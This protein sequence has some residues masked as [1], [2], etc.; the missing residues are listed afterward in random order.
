MDNT[1]IAQLFIGPLFLVLA[2][3]FRAFPP[4]SI[5]SFYGYR[6]AYSMTSQE[7]WDEANRYS[8]NLML[9]I[10]IIVT[11]TQVVLQFTVEGDLKMLIPTIMLVTLLIAM[12]PATEVHLRKHFDKEG[13]PKSR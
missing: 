9:W 5:N 11:L 2:I 1:L 13:K 3:I 7:V 12:I 8:F 10:G 4:K 6:T